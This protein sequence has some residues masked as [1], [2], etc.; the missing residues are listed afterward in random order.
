MNLRSR[1]L[2][3]R[4]LLVD[5]DGVLTDAG[6]T[7]DADGRPITQFD[8]QDGLG[9]RLWRMVGHTVGIVTGRVSAAVR[10]RAEQL[11][12]DIFHEG[13]EDKWRTAESILA[14]HGFA[15]N[16]VCY[17]GDDLPDVPVIRRVGLG[18][19]VANARLEVR[20]AAD[21]VTETPGGSGA[22][23]EVIETVL[24]HQGRWGDVVAQTTSTQ[25]ANR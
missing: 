25:A 20:Q 14:E 15:A 21:W 2:P 1:C 5:V 10:Q 8:I 3:I 9:M 18:V 6:V 22:V 17:V 24:K 23:R 11:S 19:A 7:F 13:I 12:I 16:E 4:L